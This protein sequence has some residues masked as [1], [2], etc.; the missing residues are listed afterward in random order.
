MDGGA[1][2][3]THLMV[4][5]RDTTERLTHTHTHTHNAY[6][7]NLGKWYRRIY[8]QGS[9]GETDLENRLLGMGREEERVRCMERVTRKLTLPYVK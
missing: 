8:L 4:S 6:I 2:W 9:I 7:R 1:W 3:D 5:Q